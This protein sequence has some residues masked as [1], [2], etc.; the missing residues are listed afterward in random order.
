MKMKQRVLNLKY[1]SDKLYTEV[2]ARAETDL[3]N[4]TNSV[5]RDVKLILHPEDVETISYL[6]DYCFDTVKL[7]NVNDSKI[8]QK[9]I[10]IWITIY[11]YIHKEIN[12]IK[13]NKITE[14]YTVLKNKK[15]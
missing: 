4:T 7:K 6:L 2:P 9:R 15:I 13:S 5:F 11:K 1:I 14:Y 8:K 10:K 12:K 3:K